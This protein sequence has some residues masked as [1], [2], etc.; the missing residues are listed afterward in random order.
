MAFTAPSTWSE[1]VKG[2]K[3]ITFNS[4]L[5]SPLSQHHKLIP[6][7][8]YPSCIP[9]LNPDSIV[10]H[11]VAFDLHHDPRNNRSSDPL[12]SPSVAR[13]TNHLDGVGCGRTQGLESGNGDVVM[14]REILSLS[15][16][17]CVGRQG[18]CFWIAL[19]SE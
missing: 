3:P 18:G 4:S 12:Q 9:R 13:F 11:Y 17:E 19:A 10:P 8:L 16:S 14:G 1:I 6:L 15:A 5:P 2:N 7:L